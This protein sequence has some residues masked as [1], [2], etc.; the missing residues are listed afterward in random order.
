MPNTKEINID[1]LLAMGNESPS[2]EPETAVEVPEI[3][4]DEL[5]EGWEPTA[6]NS[7]TLYDE[8][9]DDGQVKFIG[10]EGIKTHSTAEDAPLT[11]IVPN[12]EA[13]KELERH[14]TLAAKLAA[15]TAALGE[16]TEDAAFKMPVVDL[17]LN[18]E[19][20]G[21]PRKLVANSVK[22]QLEGIAMPKTSIFEA[23][24]AD[25]VEA[26]PTN[27][28]EV[29]TPVDTN[30]MEQEAYSD[31][32][33]DTPKVPK[34]EALL[35]KA[36]IR[37]YFPK[38]KNGAYLLPN[39][40]KINSDALF[41]EYV[42]NFYEQYNHPT[43]MKEDD[44]YRK[45]YFLRNFHTTEEEFV[46]DFAKNM[47]ARL[48][49]I[50]ADYADYVD[51]LWTDER[52]KQEARRDLTR[53]YTPMRKE[54]PLR[55]AINDARK[56]INSAE[57][58]NYWRGFAETFSWEDIAS[59]GMSGISSAVDELTALNKYIEGKPLNDQEK[60][61]IDLSMLKQ[62]VAEFRSAYNDRGTF[63]WNRVGNIVGHMPQFMF[64]L[65]LTGTAFST[66]GKK[67]A[68]EITFKAVRDAMKQSTSEGLKMA[69][70]KL[71]YSVIQDALATPTM[72]MSYKN[73]ADRRLRHYSWEDSQLLKQE[74][75]LLLD[76]AKALGE[77]FV[78]RH[79]EAIG[80]WITEG[81][82]YGGKV[83]AQAK[84]LDN[85]FGRTLRK[86]ANVKVPETV[87]NIRK[88]FRIGGY[89][90][91][92]GSEIYNNLISPLFT[93]ETEAWRQLC[94]DEYYW[95]LMVS[96]AIPGAAHYALA[97]PSYVRH[98]RDIKNLQKS[99]SDL[100]SKIS[101]QELKELLIDVMSSDKLEAGISKLT[102]IDWNN[103]S[104]ADAQ[105]ANRYIFDSVQMKLMQAEELE[106]ERLNAFMP[107]VENVSSSLY[108]GKNATTPTLGTK[109]HIAQLKN[110]KETFII[111]GDMNDTGST[112]V[113][114]RNEL[115]E[116]V[117]INK[118][119]IEDVKVVDMSNY[120]AEQY[121]LLFSDS[122]NKEKIANVI[123]D[124]R[125]ARQNN[126]S[127]DT[128]NQIIN[129]AGFV[130]FN[131][132][133]QVTL[134]D[135]ST[136]VVQDH[137]SG[138]YKV[139][140]TADSADSV[141]VGFL[142]V[143]QP[144]QE[145]ADAQQ[146]L[147]NQ[148]EE[149]D[150]ADTNADVYTSESSILQ[151]SLQKKAQEMAMQDGQTIYTIRLSDGREAFV[152]QGNIVQNEDGSID[153]D[154]SDATLVI[155]AVDSADLQQISIEDVEEVIETTTTS[156]VV[157]AAQT[158]I[159]EQI[160][161]KNLI[162]SIFEQ[163]GVVDVILI[164]GQEG[165]IV[166]L[167]D[168]TT[169]GFIFV[170][171]DNEVHSTA[172][173]LDYIAE[174][175]PPQDPTTP[176]DTNGGKGSDTTAISTPKGTA[177]KQGIVNIEEVDW[178]SLSVED[179]LNIH[180]M[181]YGPAQTLGLTRGYWKAIRKTL[182]DALAKVAAQDGVI[183]SLKARFASLTGP[184]EALQLRKE[185]A[186]A[187][188]E[189]ARLAA[190]ATRIERQMQKY[191]YAINKLGV[192]T[193]EELA[194]ITQRE[195][196]EAE[197][198]KQDLDEAAKA[199]IDKQIAENAIAQTEFDKKVE[200]R[201]AELEGGNETE[202]NSVEKN[203]A[204]S[205]RSIADSHNSS[206]GSLLQE[207]N[208]QLSVEPLTPNEDVAKVSKNTEIAKRAA[209]KIINEGGIRRKIDTS[210]QAISAVG[211][212]L[213][214]NKSKSSQ[215]F[216]GDYY[217]GDYSIGDNILH[218]RVSTH[219]ATD[220]RMGNEPADHKVSIVIRKNGEHRDTGEHNGYEEIVY[221]PS[222]IT[223]IEAANAIINGIQ[224]LLETGKYID[225]TGKARTTIYPPSSI[226]TNQSNEGENVS[227]MVSNTPP[228]GVSQEKWDAVVGL[229]EET[230]GTDS[231]VTDVNKMREVLDYLLDEEGYQN[232]NAAFSMRTYAEEGRQK[233]VDYVNSRVGN[234]L[235]TETEAAD[236]VQQMDDIYNI[237]QEY[238][239]KYAPFGEWSDAAVVR[240]EEGKP[241]F[242]VIKKNGEYAMNLDFSLVCKKRR[243][244][245]AV[246]R[247]M[248]DRG[249]IS[250][251]EL[252][253]VDVAKIND[254]IRRFGFETACRLCFVDAK[255]FRVAQVADVFC[256]M[257][258][259][260]I[261]LNDEQLRAVIAEEGNTTR[262]KI[263]KM[264]IEHPENRVKLSRANFMESKGFE[265]M[266]V[267]KEA[268]MK[269]YNMKKGTG[270]PKASYGDTQYV[271]DI[272][273]KQ[274]TPEA[275]YEVGGVRLQSFSDYVP[276]M[277]FDYIQM[278]ADLAAKELPAHAYTKEVLF[279]QTFGLT[280]IKINLS[281]VPKVVEG[282]IAP[283]LDAEGNY[284]WQEGETFPYEEAI[285][286]QNAE[287]YKENC[288]TIAVGVSDAHIAKLLDDENIRMVIP[289]HKSGLNKAV[290]I[291]NNIDQFTD[292]TNEQ[293][294]RRADGTKL[295]KAQAKAHFNFNAKF[296]K[297]GNARAAADAYL[298]W[299]DKK[300]YIPKFDQF[301]DHPNYYKLLEDF[302]TCITENGVDT[303]VPQQPVQMNFPTEQSAF[304]S[305]ATL[306]EK[307][308]EEDA[309]LEGQRNSQL[310]NIVDTI[311]NELGDKV[312]EAVEDAD[313]SSFRKMKT[314]KGEVYGFTYNGKIY[315]DPTT[316]NLEAPVHEYTELWCS[317]IE[318]QNPALW[319]KGVE[320]LKQTN[321]WEVV[322]SDPNYRNL[323]E[324]LRA[325]ETL[326]RIVAAEAAKKISEV[327]DSK[328]LIAKLRA[329]IRKFWNELKA[330]FS[331][332]TKEDI[333]KLTL[334]EFKAMPSRDLIE[335]IDPR[336]YQVE[337][338][339]K[340]GKKS[341]L[342][343]SQI[344]SA[345]DNIGTFDSAEDDIRYSQ[346]SA[347]DAEYMDA[348]R[349][350]D[351]ERAKEL[352]R[353]YAETRGYTTSQNFRD[354]HSAPTATVEKKD[355]IN[356]ELINQ[357]S[358]DD[359]TDVNLF[360]LPQGENLAPN[361]FW[362]P[363]GPRWYMYNDDAGM[364]AYAAISSAIRSINYQ[365]SKY[366]E[367]RDIPTVKVYRAV[368]NSVEA[369]AL[370][371]GDWVTP[372]K[373]YADR[374]GKARFGFNEYKIIEQEVPATELWWDAN[375][376][377]EWGYD[378]G[379]V[380]ATANTPNNVKLLD[381][382]TYD[383]DGN[384]IPLSSRFDQSVEDPRFMFVG[385]EGA[386]AMDAAEEASTRLDNLAVAREMENSG[387]DALSIKQATGWERG[388]DQ[389]WRYEVPDVVINQAAEL[390]ED[391]ETLTTTLGSLVLS[392]ELFNAYPELKDTQVI[393]KELA[394]GRYGSY[395]KG[396]NDAVG[397]IIL[398]D[399]FVNKTENPQ[400]VEAMREVNAHPLVR[401]WNRIA[402]AETFDPAAFDK[403][404]KALRQ[405]P[406]WEKFNALRQENGAIPRYINQIAGQNTLVHEIQHA[407]QEKEGFAQ[408]GTT[409]GL[410]TRLSERLNQLTDQ[411]NQ[412]RAEGRDAEADGII[413][414][415]RGLAE[416]V[417]NND[418][419]VLGNYKK[420]AGEVEA[421]NVS[422][423]LNM[424]PEQR[425]ETLAAE[426]AD[427]APEDQIFLYNSMESSNI[428][429]IFNSERRDIEKRAKA[430]GTWLKAPNGKD[431]NLTPEQWVTV[432]SR[433]FKGWAGDW[434]NDPENATKVLDQ[435][436]E[437]MPVHH[438]T[439]RD[440]LTKFNVFDTTKPAWF[441]K[442]KDYAQRYNRAS[443]LF[444]FSDLYTVFLDIRDP[445]VIPSVNYS[446]LL[447]DEVEQ[448]KKGFENT[449]IPL[450]EIEAL[451]EEMKPAELWQMTNSEQFKKLAEKYGYDGI[452][453]QEGPA[454]FTYATFKSAQVKSV[455]N[456]A[457]D[458]EN[459]DIRFMVEGSETDSAS[460]K[461][462]R[463]SKVEKLQD[464]I[465]AL[466]NELHDNKKSLKDV[467][468]RVYEFLTS[469]DVLNAMET[470]VGKT[471]YRSVLKAITTAIEQSYGK[472]DMNV[473]R[474][475]VDKYLWQ[476]EDIMAR[477][478][479]HRRLNEI[480]QILNT[481]VEGYTPQGVR[482]GKR[483]DEKTR[484]TF[485]TIRDAIAESFVEQTEE[486][487]NGARRKPVKYRLRNRTEDGD[488]A[489]SY[490]LQTTGRIANITQQADDIIADN[491]DNT[492]ATAIQVSAN[493]VYIANVLTSYDATLELNEQIGTVSEEIDELETKIQQATA[494]HRA[495]A[496]GSAEKVQLWND[497][498][499]FRYAKE[500]AIQNRA[501]L[502]KSYAARLKTFTETLKELVELGVANL[503]NAEVDKIEKEIA[504]KV[505]I[506]RSVK[507]PSA[508]VLPNR[509]YTEKGKKKSRRSAKAIK[510]SMLNE[511]QFMGTFA[512]LSKEIDIASIPGQWLEDGWYY[513]FMLSPEGYM[514]RADWRH[515]EEQR[516]QKLMEDKTKEIFERSSL[517]SKI[518]AQS[519]N[520][521]NIVAYEAQKES[522]FKISELAIKTDKDGKIVG[523]VQRSVP[524]TIGNLLYIRNIVRQQGG[525]AGY[526]TWGISEE[527]LD[528]MVAYVEQKYPEYCQFSDWVVRELIPQLYEQQD[529]I[530]FERF[531]THLTKTHDYFPIVRDKRFVGKIAEVGEG[532]VSMPSSVTGN[533]VERVKTSAKMDL[534]ADMFTV[535]RNHIKE[536]LDWIAY[537]ELTRK[538]N[539]MSTSHAFRNMMEAQDFSVDK[540]K[541]MYEIAIGQ[542]KI[543]K[544]DNTALTKTLNTISKN[545]VAA[546]L[547][548]NFNAA[549]KQL[550]S[551]TA[552]LGYTADPKFVPIWA[553]N[554]F[555]PSVAK[556]GVQKIIQMIKEGTLNPAEALDAK[557][558]F[559]N[560]R[561][562]LENIPT[563]RA[564][565]E[566]RHAGFE[567]F[568]AEGVARWEK[569]TSW[570]STVG[571]M[572]NAF[573]DMLT[574][575]NGARAVYEYQ[576]A[577]N[578]ARG[579]SKEDAHRDACVKAAV[580][581]NET[582]QSGLDAF[583]SKFQAGGGM[584]RLL[585]VGLGA[586]QNTAMS[587]A[588]NEHYSF[589]QVIRMLRKKNR[590]RM[591]DFKVQEYQSKGK[592]REEAEKLATKEFKLAFWSQVNSV[593]HNSIF[594]NF[595]WTL[596][597]M[598]STMFS[599]AFGGMDWDDDKWFWESES[600][601]K[602]WHNEDVRKQFA[603]IFSWGTILWQLPLVYNHPI[604]KQ[605][606]VALQALRKGSNY[607]STFESPVVS[608][609]DD[610][611]ES[612]SK[613]WSGV[614]D[615]ITGEV[616]KYETI[617]TEQT[618]EHI[619]WAF[620]LKTGLT[621]NQR[622]IKNISDGIKGMIEDG[623]D[624]EDIMN[625]LSSPRSLT[626][627]IAGEP[628][629]GE[630]TEQ[631]LD[632][633]SYVYRLINEG[634]GIYD[635]KWQRE[636]IDEYIRKR[637]RPLY[638]AM[639]IDP[640]D[641]QALESHKKAI[642]KIL[643]LRRAGNLSKVKEGK[644]D[645]FVGLSPKAKDVHIEMYR[646]KRLID[647]KE[648]QLKYM[649]EFDDE[650][651][652]LLKEKYKLEQ[653]LY[654]KWKEYIKL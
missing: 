60:L 111:H 394:E 352:V 423:R 50:E 495:A 400:W 280:G 291:H 357:Q 407:I 636:R 351:M 649:V 319:A 652:A 10:A 124:I 217:E 529:A 100:L 577:E 85:T 153:T 530:Y 558:F 68:K 206:S 503:K 598:L 489:T 30:Q 62:E 314:S 219:P 608:E 582:Q 192:D 109:L 404:D 251:Y 63:S 269:L 8:K 16:T 522:G 246:F 502:R 533:I 496:P 213:H 373:L 42:N 552:I 131:V 609:I 360:S 607:G 354:A 334:R 38:D 482:V 214:M 14:K 36:T 123:S 241:V 477:V 191:E 185:V 41:E 245:D 181:E 602:F 81:M 165:K 648:L 3:N 71:G 253:Q 158:N 104:A 52:M 378:N 51:K 35:S 17:G 230:L 164:N 258:N 187:E 179:Y 587:F 107:L 110:G 315:L 271:N 534:T 161:K 342:L 473:V 430:D 537:S 516:I 640:L 435:N 524:L 564:R 293:N 421:R 616:K 474:Q 34:K 629:K 528:Q 469:A 22:K 497:L 298:K 414:N 592:S 361:D 343:D 316:L 450:S 268:I 84:F 101:N 493:L 518:K 425:R 611:L 119:D 397:T 615:P 466:R 294:T 327:S 445:L 633:M 544:T 232:G 599:V 510:R 647:A 9:G 203:A 55:R 630:T 302:T 320:L 451:I 18:A 539:S 127:N 208:A 375:D 196:L 326:S 5:L 356:A 311:E 369:T 151:Q 332:W 114:A 1:E 329:W 93:G 390:V 289:Y 484:N 422:A 97:V 381:P 386:A 454:N 308:L 43:L 182:K 456:R 32:M 95:E 19:D 500:A 639:G 323:S 200:R 69:G 305:L 7:T 21:D 73:L 236:I 162:T 172:I 420:L 389:M 27:N 579:L 417:I 333:S 225:T 257:Y 411:I 188:A 80:L 121:S 596:G 433:A 49:K 344:K 259:P 548:F 235:L 152:K 594:S 618:V 398:S 4:I 391:G 541:E 233:L 584:A 147:A 403:A 336:K 644:A 307:G 134:T 632:R 610:L 215:S 441:A 37:S 310:D 338:F 379:N 264:L 432:R 45:N 380:E 157:A 359:S 317:V 543:N 330:T 6:D 193:T 286:L 150:K 328:T 363:Q 542:G 29:R 143:L 139:A 313:L 439:V 345:I 168:G 75:P 76:Y 634:S 462:P 79:S 593:L 222:E 443:G 452:F 227:A 653:D 464:K 508:K 628:R 339:E 573:V 178:D 559:D 627:S 637:E 195:Q 601:E 197:Q 146:E 575:A 557:A 600:W 619:V 331:Q 174:V 372:S 67:A 266:T 589:A 125:T 205:E 90:G 470:G 437:P 180:I 135:G 520:L 2:V 595:A 565:W 438:G 325:S 270:G 569:L 535:L 385:E 170:G 106:T 346:L 322:N 116:T 527:L 228:K 183:A 392:D 89:T 413:K 651:A 347:I 623:V 498:K 506:Y 204:S 140:P 48:D 431:T 525:K 560:W 129:N 457:F 247:R 115:G 40:K 141:W 166:E 47:T 288:G 33:R 553:K 578:I 26:I 641:A 337:I 556:L 531:G 88:T 335:G 31:L 416:A 638:E 612:I 59:Y 472:K 184:A 367:V 105:A 99:T 643:L 15:E 207:G 491:A 212:G 486:T 429:D 321:T 401:Q 199:E 39:G 624:V 216:Y 126:A 501:N 408:G 189:R 526:V 523:G 568:K 481:T 576:Y 419:D 297:S 642:E 72:A 586:Y 504:W 487:D 480:T 532:E 211:N 540:L 395:A 492:S 226:P 299:C 458:S 243:T 358:M 57:K 449:R 300:G 70:K 517:W 561:W 46:R 91:E 646:L 447:G 260:L 24:Y 355:F 142:N 460:P 499:A 613:Q 446:F 65:G 536:T 377:R 455:N 282:G 250:N 279:A 349:S 281:L 272:L 261:D 515:N 471:Q 133:E 173:S 244:L 274:W 597:G 169:Y 622:V 426:T 461:A 475:I 96:M 94:T 614:V 620:L 428:L 605:V 221:E 340:T 513:Q 409:T 144:N 224:S 442:Y 171:Q 167:I 238:K 156:E 98:F 306:I 163:Y 295:S 103:V 366:G 240:D 402:Y 424:T 148:I 58:D 239:D 580:M 434:I 364:Q 387:N 248:I 92:V 591:I 384:I 234:S 275:A 631:Y 507:D 463:R 304:G 112:T 388:A 427:V 645:E 249:I 365:L 440:G 490:R 263:A 590:E 118:S 128:F 626:R 113:V 478:L 256:E 175:L 177:P 265:N 138:Y 120:I 483:I 362:S 382:I 468:Y 25:F 606:L 583:I 410:N 509:D 546:N 348:V 23:E 376:A 562:A 405:S 209:Q 350:G 324:D 406:I 415:N 64:E 223:P 488:I 145:I 436:G 108:S 160:A 550:I 54:D 467:L 210:E 202:E 136:W 567:V 132:G 512:E 130:F 459:D 485:K 87:S 102:A 242:S 368:P 82:V 44:N 56:I 521:L 465:T 396:K 296:R 20:L 61:Y 547:V 650:R 444:K 66:I 201:V 479:A 309:V 86:V 12:I 28:G 252:G 412:L 563:L 476:A 383:N 549:A 176:E 154:S 494:A 283:G 198:Q 511:N 77:T 519:F 194:L 292:Y 555:V 13:Q 11:P 572:P 585:G 621:L 604:S 301:R 538:F 276:R 318:K 353:Q 255:R 341:L 74:A 448:I 566:S 78:E 190:E 514:F 122:A 418:A 287:G 186:E 285:T 218:L 137:K 159:E 231:I 53:E 570:I 551:M 278:V 545:L 290:A 399:V 635:S 149:S 654:N 262:G 505:G 603:D 571:L 312:V 237:C 254:I 374:H 625:F 371:N 83:L 117:A 393:F 581:V 303:F 229:L 554:Y 220:T 277:V 617:R 453:T 273:G 284:V 588:R 370:Q 267:N 574:C 155:K